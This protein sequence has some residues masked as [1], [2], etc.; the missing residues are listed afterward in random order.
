MNRDI[1]FRGKRAD[2]GKWIVNSATYIRDGDG[3][4]LSDED[5]DVVKVIPETVGQFTG[6]KY[7]NTEDAIC[8]GDLFYCNGFENS[9]N[10]CVYFTRFGVVG[11][12]AHWKAAN[13]ECFFDHFVNFPTTK[14][15]HA[16]NIHDNPELLS[17]KP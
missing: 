11:Y 15:F 4:W 5:T 17:D 7:E 8:V 14:F 16:G 10:E 6:I 12:M 2:N 9:I 1:E 3:I 13:K